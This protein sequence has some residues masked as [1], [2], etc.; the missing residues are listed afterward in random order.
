[1]RRF[2]TCYRKFLLGVENA[3]AFNIKEQKHN[4]TY[5]A[6]LNVSIFIHVFRIIAWLTA[7][8]V[9]FITEVE[10]Q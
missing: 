10:G 1:M 5:E 6:Y 7:S 8:G 9:L 3:Q 2:A 4:A